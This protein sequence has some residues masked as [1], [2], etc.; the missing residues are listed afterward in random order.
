M[1]KLG[2]N[3]VLTAMLVCS[4]V[5]GVTVMM[6]GIALWRAGSIC[7]TD[8]QGLSGGDNEGITMPRAHASLVRYLRRI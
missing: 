8:Q 6:A 1:G 3:P 7:P 5:L 4:M 2:R